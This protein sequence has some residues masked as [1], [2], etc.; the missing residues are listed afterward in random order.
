MSAEHHTV[1]VVGG[2]PAGLPL[3]VVLGGR[4][5]FYRASRIFETRYGPLANHLRQFEGSL[6]GMDMQN[7]KMAFS[8]YKAFRYHSY[9]T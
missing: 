6:L 3:A 8:P 7:K 4:H 5:P 2:G 1:I 9:F